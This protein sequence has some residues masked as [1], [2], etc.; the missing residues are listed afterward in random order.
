M[1]RLFVALGFDAEL[2]DRIAGLQRGLP[3]ARWTEPDDLHLTLRFIGEVEEEIAEEIHHQLD[4][5]AFEP[6]A[7]TLA[8]IG[9]FGDR[10]RAHTLWLGA[11]RNPALDAL[12]AKVDAAVSRAG[13]PA[14]SRKFTPHVTL[15]RVKEAVPARL[16][17]FIDGAGHFRAEHIAVTRFTLYRSIL[18][19]QGAHYQALEHYPG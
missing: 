1:I 17:A 5:I 8:G 6:F 9:M 4:A 3:G 2:N 13:V 19:R 18:G 15:A 12:A 14:E 7:L 16:Q 10:H 11:E